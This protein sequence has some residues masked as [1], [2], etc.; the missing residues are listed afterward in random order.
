MMRYVESAIVLTFGILTVVFYIITSCKDP[1]IL[2]KEYKFLHLLEF[3]H[4]LDMCPYCQVLRT[5][6]SRHCNICNKCCERFD[7]HCPWTNNCV[8]IK[9]HNSFMAFLTSLMLFMLSYYVTF[10]QAVYQII[11]GYPEFTDPD[12][13]HCK[14]IN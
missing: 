5:P 8:G 13:T 11:T 14:Y 3:V 1:G 9:N 7:H 2:K 12:V 10:G 6:R 4:P